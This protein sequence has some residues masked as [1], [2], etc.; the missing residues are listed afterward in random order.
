MTGPEEEIVPDS[1]YIADTS[2]TKATAPGN[3]ESFPADRQVPEKKDLDFY[4]K[5]KP[6]RVVTRASVLRNEGE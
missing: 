2:T 3:I 5:A 6:R 4:S 1:E